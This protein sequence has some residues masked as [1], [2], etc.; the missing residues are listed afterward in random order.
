MPMS[1]VKTAVSRAGA[2]FHCRL[3]AEAAFLRDR[4]DAHDYASQSICVA[5]G[6]L[7]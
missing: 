5:S 7:M 2:Q 6:R 1:G 4:R 3:A